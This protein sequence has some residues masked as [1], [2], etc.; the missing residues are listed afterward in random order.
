MTAVERPGVPELRWM[1][2]D[3]ADTDDVL[4]HEWLFTNVRVG[5]ARSDG[6]SRT[7]RRP[8]SGWSKGSTRRQRSA[9]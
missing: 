6:R 3:L 1:P 2:R 9:H 7:L 8:R 5:S 4:R